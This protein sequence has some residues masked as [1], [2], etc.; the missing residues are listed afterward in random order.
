MDILENGRV[1]RL[2]GGSRTAQ[3]GTRQAPGLRSTDAGSI[4]NQ[5]VI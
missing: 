5:M 2:A 1:M 3:A 4:L